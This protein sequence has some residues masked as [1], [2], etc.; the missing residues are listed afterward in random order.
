[1]TAAGEVPTVKAVTEKAIS[2]VEGMAGRC[3]G[4]IVAAA[5]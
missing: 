4:K 2:S 5:T 1:M 3:R